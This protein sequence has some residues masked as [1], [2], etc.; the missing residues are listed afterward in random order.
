MNWEAIGAIGEIAGAYWWDNEARYL[1]YSDFVTAI[2]MV[3]NAEDRK[4]QGIT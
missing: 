3:R 2:E 1:Y 4:D